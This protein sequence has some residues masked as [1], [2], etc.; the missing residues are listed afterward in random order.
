MN[1]EELLKKSEQELTDI[2]LDKYGMRVD[3]NLNKQKL[4]DAIHKLDKHA[5]HDS[6]ATIDAATKQYY[7][8]NSKVTNINDEPIVKIRFT[9]LDG[10]REVKFRSNGGHPLPLK[11]KGKGAKAKIPPLWHFITGQIYEVPWNV[12][13]HLNNLTVWDSQPALQEDGSYINKPVYRRRFSSEIV[14][15]LNQV[16]TIKQKELRESEALNGEHIKAG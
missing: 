13:E 7:D 4:V 2:L 5:I 12:H 6:H 8:M 10:S 14:T 3:A 11:G 15:T 1:N 16:K 9:H